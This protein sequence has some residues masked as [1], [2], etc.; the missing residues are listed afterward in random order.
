[1]HPQKNAEGHRRLVRD[2]AGRG[3]DPSVIFCAFL[4]MCSGLLRAHGERARRSFAIAANEL[5]HCSRR[6]RQPSTGGARGTRLTPFTRKPFACSHE[7]ARGMNPA[8]NKSSPSYRCGGLQVRAA[9]QGDRSPSGRRR[10]RRQHQAPERLACPARIINACR[11]PSLDMSIA[12]ARRNRI[13]A[14]FLRK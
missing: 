9:P 12:L 5:V 1:M 11:K 8:A 3:I 6:E 4:W 13:A 7:L 14:H 10:C 2:A